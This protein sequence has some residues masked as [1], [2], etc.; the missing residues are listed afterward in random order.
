MKRL[1]YILL[2]IITTNYSFSSNATDSLTLGNCIGKCVGYL[3]SNIKGAALCIEESVAQTISENEITDISIY[4]AAPASLINDFSIFISD[5]LDEAPIYEQKATT[6]CIG[7]NNIKFDKPFRIEGKQIFIGFKYSGTSICLASK[8]SDY[9]EYVLKDNKWEILNNANG[10]AAYI[11]IKGNNIPDNFV[12][13][14]IKTPFGYTVTGNKCLVETSILNLSGTPITSAEFRCI[15]ENRIS[16]YKIEN[17]NIGHLEEANVPI[18]NIV[19]EDEGKINFKIELYKLNG[20]DNVRT[21]KSVSDTFLITSIP[22]DKYIPRNVLIEVFSTENCTGC[23]SGHSTLDKITDEIDNIVELGH[24][25]GFYTD[26]FTI[27]ESIE[28]EIFY[29]GMKFAPAINVDRTSFF[30]RYGSL[31]IYGN[32]GT[33]SSIGTE[34]EDLLKEASRIPAFADIDIETNME[35][36]NIINATIEGKAIL[37]LPESRNDRLFVFLSED[38][39][40]SESQAGAGKSYYHRHVARQ[41][42]TGAW[43]KEINLE[44]GFR[45]SFSFTIPKEWNISRM[46]LIAFVGNYN[47]EDIFDCQIYNS[48]Q[49]SLAH[50]ASTGIENNKIA[51]EIKL[52]D[53]TIMFQY[54][55]NSLMLFD[56]SGKC[57]F[58]GHD[59]KTFQLENLP[60]GIYI[61][62][63]I[64]KGNLISNKILLK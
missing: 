38:S 26:K 64:S 42:L 33:I 50:Y 23:P 49:V 59:S 25:S 21:D 16:S 30:S 18:E 13:W 47:H 27:D 4:M 34:T 41:C 54:N 32:I 39:I 60:E 6:Y 11:V 44:N 37:E 22:E 45:E 1:F 48:K 61:Y 31:Y 17:L 62:K 7:W 46:K 28:Y 40:F 43:G 58:Q 2:F 20:I 5:N 14:S 56:I 52:I 35:E 53:R 57:I 15:T 10:I 24:H 55:V 3:N 9:K 63:A 8:T 51:D 36:D 29:G 12:E 19:F